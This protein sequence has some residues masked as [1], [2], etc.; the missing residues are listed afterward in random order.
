MIIFSLEC[1]LLISLDLESQDIEKIL[2][3]W[4][5]DEIADSPWDFDKDWKTQYYNVG[6]FLD[7]FHENY[8]KHLERLDYPEYHFKEILEIDLQDL[9]GST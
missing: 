7:W 3:Q 6:N 8:D 4:W 5:D 9:G 1:E 2:K